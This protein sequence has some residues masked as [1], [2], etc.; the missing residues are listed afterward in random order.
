M[1]AAQVP[2]I[3]ARAGQ[4]LFSRFAQPAAAEPESW[5]KVRQAFAPKSKVEN[6][7]GIL[8]VSGIL[9]FKPDLGSLFFDGF[10]DSGEVLGAFRRLEA[11]PEAKSIVLNVNSPE[12][13]ALA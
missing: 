8:E 9:A 10:E 11:D 2:M 4:A 12:D 3:E 5:G 6:G 1:L 7:V 13:L